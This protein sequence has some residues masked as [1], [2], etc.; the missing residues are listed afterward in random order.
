MN[1]TEV[2]SGPEIYT[3]I[4]LFDQ[5]P[6]QYQ[7]F[8]IP[9][10]SAGSRTDRYLKLNGRLMGADTLTEEECSLFDELFQDL[11]SDPQF[12]NNGGQKGRLSHFE[13]GIESH[14]SSPPNV[15][16]GTD[17]VRFVRTGIAL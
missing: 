5:I 8:V 1:V 10:V 17:P 4:I 2:S 14:G 6:E 12:A 11:S 15:F 9:G 16:F 13:F 7:V 3:M